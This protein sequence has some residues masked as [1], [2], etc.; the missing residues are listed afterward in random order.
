MTEHKNFKQQLAHEVLL[1]VRKHIPNAA[2][3]DLWKAT[4]AAAL[5][6]YVLTQVQAF[7]VGLHVYGWVLFACG[8]A[9][10]LVTFTKDGK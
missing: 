6:G 2:A 3:G 5:A 8:L 9:L 1:Q 7:G 10:S 4:L